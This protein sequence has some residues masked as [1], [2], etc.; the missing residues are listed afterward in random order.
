MILQ[1]HPIL[2]TLQ[3]TGKWFLISELFGLWFDLQ[4]IIESRNFP[5]LKV[6]AFVT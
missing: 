6:I 2:K 5:G 3:G 4:K 1:I